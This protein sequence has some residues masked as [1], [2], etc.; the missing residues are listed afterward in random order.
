MF[1]NTYFHKAC[2]MLLREKKLP[3]ETFHV[4]RLSCRRFLCQFA[5]LSINID[6]IIRI[7]NIFDNF[8]KI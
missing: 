6:W 4:I 8:G 3:I 2:N 5:M 1:V 7:G